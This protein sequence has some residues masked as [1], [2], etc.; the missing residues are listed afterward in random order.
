MARDPSI[1]YPSFAEA[2]GMPE[3]PDSLL[4]SR[5]NFR[6]RTTM[7]GSNY[8]RL[9]SWRQGVSP[10]RSG[11]RRQRE[12]SYEHSAQG[13][14]AATSTP[15]SAWEV[16][17]H[18]TP[19]ESRPRPAAWEARSDPSSQDHLASLVRSVEML[20]GGIAGG[21]VGASI[22][23][24]PVATSQAH[25]FAAYQQLTVPLGAAVG[26]LAAFVLVW[27]RWNVRRDQ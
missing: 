21:L 13:Q 7:P 20:A 5:L 10:R 6:R 18:P 27:K 12:G 11:N 3:L 19:P 16:E 15:P 17:D 4:A 22:A 1:Q 9:S 2:E 25:F 14:P 26:M 24:I 23:A 8:S